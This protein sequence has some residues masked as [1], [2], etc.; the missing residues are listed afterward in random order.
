MVVPNGLRERFRRQL[1]TGEMILF[2]GAG[3]SYDARTSSGEAVP[4]VSDLRRDLAALAF[5]G[6]QE[7]DTDSSLGDLFDVAISRNEGKT[8][9]LFKS[10]L[11]VSA[12][13]SPPRFASWF[14]APWQRHYTLNIDD[15]DEAIGAATSSLPR[16]IV[17]VSGH[18]QVG[19]QTADLLSVHLNGRLKDFPDVTFSMRQYAQRAGQ[20][21]PWYATLAVD[22]LTKPVLFVGTV[23]EEAGLWQHI[24]LRRNRQRADVELRPAS[25]LVTPQLPR[26]R[27]AL[28][29]SYNIDWIEATE[30][31]FFDEV[32]AGSTLDSEHGHTAIRRRFHPATSASSI[33]PIDKFGIDRSD[34]FLRLF[35][36]GRDPV[37]E[38][39]GASG[40]AV[41]RDFE[42]KLADD[43]ARGEDD[44][45]L[46]TGTA[47]SGKTTTGLRLA[48]ALQA[49]GRRVFAY[50][51]VH[52]TASSAR[53]VHAARNIRPEV[54]FID[55][56]DVFGD[57]VGRTL[58]ELSEIGSIKQVIATIRSS[59][60]HGLSLEDEL[61]T[62]RWS[63]HT[64]PQLE[65]SDIDKIVA[66]L[67]RA[68]R[69]GRMSGM[70]PDERRNIFR[71]Q[72]GRQLLVAMYYATSGDQLEDR[73][74]SE[75]EDLS[76]SSRAA[77]GMAA[78]ATEAHQYVT[79]QELV[80]GLTFLGF[81]IDGNAVLNDIERLLDRALLVRTEDGI[82][83]R[84]R[85][86]AEKS[87][88]FFSDNGLLNRIVSGFCFSLATQV[89]K[90]TPRHTRERRLLRRLI[91]H[92]RLQRT[93]I[94]VELCRMVYKDL[95]DRLDWD[96]HYWLQ[97]GSL[98]VEAG[99][100]DVAKS[101]LDSAR[102]LVEG[103][104]RFVENEYDYLLLKRASQDPTSTRSRREAAEALADLEA[105]MH[106]RGEEDSHPYH[107]YGS[108][109]LS[110]ARRSSMTKDEKVT[111]TRKL[112]DAVSQG[113]R[114]HPR[115]D[116]L[117]KLEADLRREYLLIST[118][119]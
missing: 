55:E 50:D 64:I 114:H 16:D 117:R 3:F 78:L 36:E 102:S 91:N 59:K 71:E 118:Q 103:T 75:C 66:S 18:R 28:L 92:D 88:D 84:H 119:I 69:L 6:S 98:E 83:V 47:A 11:S 46:L 104:D 39:V 94:D 41:V 26:A 37:W 93:V 65:N 35:L 97:R 80:T 89:D 13:A 116:D 15:L 101:Y 43:V 14:S 85:W 2:T 105:A 90:R 67:D 73:V 77:Y 10:K 58:R 51:S 115:R 7:V 23:L 49:R 106:N 21:D 99:D 56:I 53:L 68:G 60:L 30:K 100:L 19:V 9:E 96:S 82:R 86:I 8:R 22:L 95:Q 12:K 113:R 57:Q 70:S 25:Y 5:P 31:E 38:D 4:G 72:A 1:R 110:W 81:G 29:K 32:L 45:V 112:L 79:R 109:G 76:G 33:R 42:A 54:L 52:G 74:Y 17:A 63:D 111:F 87:L 61:D 48:L 20:P 62:V 40:F 107:V 24:E 44:V 34:D 27:A 108:Q